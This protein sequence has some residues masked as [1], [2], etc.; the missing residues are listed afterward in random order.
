MNTL[1]GIWRNNI[2]TRQF[3]EL[4]FH[5]NNET[6]YNSF[7]Q[8]RTLTYYDRRTSNYNNRNASKIK[9]INTLKGLC[10]NNITTRQSSRVYVYTSTTK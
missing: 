8:V 7:S 6:V 5:F 9:I 3:C 2:T 10:R 1:K 4:T